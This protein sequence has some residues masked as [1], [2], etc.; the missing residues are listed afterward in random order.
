MFSRQTVFR[1]SRIY[2]FINL[3][4]LFFSMANELKSE[5]KPYREG[6]CE[7]CGAYGRLYEIDGKLLCEDCKDEEFGTTEEEA[8]ENTD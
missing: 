5:K 1:Y 7:D 4:F 2:N 3:K 6:E 8:E